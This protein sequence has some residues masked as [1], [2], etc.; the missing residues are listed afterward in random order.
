MTATPQNTCHVQPAHCTSCACCEAK[1]KA[2]NKF[3]IQNIAEA[4]SVNYISEVSV[5]NTCVLPEPYVMHH[6][7]VTV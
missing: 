1:A 3:I 4:A 5:F 7:C 6:D 2:I